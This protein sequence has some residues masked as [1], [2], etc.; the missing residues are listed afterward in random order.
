MIG[1]SAIAALRYPNFALLWSAQVISAFGDRIT[2]FAL[3]FVTWQLTRS[4]L[5]TALAVV[6]STVPYAAF[7]LFGGAI[8]DA[9][10]RRRAMVLCDV[11]RLFAIGSIPP[12]LALA[13][14]LPVIYGLV[15]IAALCSA[16]FSPARLAIVP[17]LIPATRL[18]A[19]NSMV[20]ASDRAV[21]IIGT[22]IAGVLVAA[23]HELAFYVDAITFGASALLLGK[24]A[25]HEAAPR[26]MSW[27]GLVA[28]AKQGLGVLG[29]SAVLR[30]NTIVRHAIAETVQPPVITLK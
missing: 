17:D 29:E 23:L 2:V 9:L 15:F 30:S 4:A 6:I 5:S 25:L 24:I 8:A 11:I 14:P 16:I 7:G 13:A 3:A 20:Y 28:D 1:A 21:E 18:G 22:L 26:S 10:G 19:G 12:L 27:R